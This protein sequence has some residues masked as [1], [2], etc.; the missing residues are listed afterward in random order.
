MDGLAAGVALIAAFIFFLVALQQ[1]QFF[2]SVILLIFAGS[3]MGFLPYNFRPA[4]I[5]MGDAGSMFIGFLLSALIILNT[6]YVPESPTF[7]PVIMPLLVLGVPIFD[8]LSVI[9][10]R[11]KKGQPI[12]TADKRHFSHRLVGLGMS[13]KQ[14][15]LFV[16]LVTFCIAINATLLRG[17]KPAEATVILIQALAIFAF[18]VFL[19]VTAGRR[20]KLTTENTE[21]NTKKGSE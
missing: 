9:F 1:G 14:A 4:T 15:V 3:L 20:I 10:L 8:T 2:V 11:L 12:F 18:I 16:Y 13:Q 19:E 17:A 6:F 21:K 7:L 5:F